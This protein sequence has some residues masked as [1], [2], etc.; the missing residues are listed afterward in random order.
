MDAS[1]ASH[2]RACITITTAAGTQ[3]YRA[4]LGNI[5]GGVASIGQMISFDGAGQFAAGTL[6]KQTATSLSN[7]NYSFGVSSAQNDA[8]CNASA[9]CGGK[10]GEAGVFQ[11]A[12]GVVNGGALDNNSNGL[13]NDNS[14]NV[15]W[16]ITPES[17]S[18]GGAYS[19]AANG[20]G[21]LTFTPSGSISAV[22]A[23]LYAVNST[24]ALILGSDDQTLSN[25]FGGEMLLQSGGPFANSALSGRSVVYFSSLN[26]PPPAMANVT[27]GTVT[28]DGAGNFPAGTLWQNNSGTIAS[29]DLSGTI[30][31]ADPSGNGRVLPTGGATNPPVFWMVTANEA[32]LLGP[33]V[34][35]E[36]GMIEP[37]TSISAP[38]GTYA[39]GTL[40]PEGW[41]IDDNSGVAT[42]SG[43]NVS[44]TSDDNAGGFMN[45]NQTLSSMSVSVDAS[46]LGSIGAAGCTVGATGSSGCQMIFY[47]ISSSRA[48]LLNLLD[49]Q[50][51]VP[52]ILALQLADQ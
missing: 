21:A 6:R 44:G 37:Q 8:L 36:S 52:N 45:A 19:F 10:F 29:Q 43:G 5:N 41:I 46:G 38:S 15:L 20:R 33:S 26:G 2:Q 42:F 16:P 27:I 40:N 24:D 47:V 23:V 12:G 25:L 51:N 34:G 22:H 9:T 18:S 13:L 3:H 39:F 14:A 4:S 11:L 7:G 32:F 49:S 50:G 17:I 1:D 35:V 30:Y 28:A 31:S 48:A